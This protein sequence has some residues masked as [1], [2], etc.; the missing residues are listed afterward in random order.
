MVGWWYV[1]VWWQ[2]LCG[3]MVC[4]SSGVLWSR[5]AY[6]NPSSSTGRFLSVVM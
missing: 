4:D 6:V 3:M 2:L 1:V 5:D